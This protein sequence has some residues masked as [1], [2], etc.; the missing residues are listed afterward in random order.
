MQTGTTRMGDTVMVATL[1][2]CMYRQVVGG[3]LGVPFEFM[4]RDTFR[5][6]GMIE[7]CLFQALE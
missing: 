2:D 5:C 7:R 1:R 4:S 6:T 3:A